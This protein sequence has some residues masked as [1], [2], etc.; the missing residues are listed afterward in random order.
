MNDEPTPSLAPNRRTSAHCFSMRASILATVA[1]G[2]FV[3]MTAATTQ[4]AECA[5]I[6]DDLN[7]PQQILRCGA[8]LSVRAAAGT[9]YHVVD[10]NG[11]RQPKA[12]QLDE[13]ALMVEFHPSPGRRTFQ[14]LTPRAIAV[15]RGTHWV[16]EATAERSSTF[17]ISGR[18]GVRRLESPPEVLLHP[19]EGADVTNDPGPI[20]VKRWAE[21][22]VRALLARFGE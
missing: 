4:A 14:I 15:V 11:R 7:P 19:G 3:A 5:L 1:I 2:F 21:P 6:P 9:N 10:E 17:V 12:L 18:V 22:R 20:V 13:G 16:V 8:N